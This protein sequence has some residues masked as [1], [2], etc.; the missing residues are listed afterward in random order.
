MGLRS[1]PPTADAFEVELGV[2]PA[3]LGVEA[4][5]VAG[6]NGAGEDPEDP[7]TGREVRTVGGGMADPE[8]L[9]VP[10]LV[11][12]LV[13]TPTGGTEATGG[14]PPTTPTGGTV[15]TGETLLTDPMGGTLPTTPTGGIWDIELGEL[16][17]P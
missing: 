3:T 12:R 5:E 15:P 9:D 13:T 2:D 17:S 10:M 11:G 7:G 1:S 8:E 4:F 14:V 6:G 16:L